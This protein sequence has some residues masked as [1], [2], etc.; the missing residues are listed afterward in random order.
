[1]GAICLNTGDRFKVSLKAGLEKKTSVPCQW[2]A[3]QTIKTGITLQEYYQSDE[4]AQTRY[5]PQQ[6]TV[7]GT[8]ILLS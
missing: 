7:S 5:L 4:G 3:L 8:E 6:L 2:F 1:M